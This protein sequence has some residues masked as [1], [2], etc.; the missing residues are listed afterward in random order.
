MRG[1]NILVPI[2][3]HSL[4]DALLLSMQEAD[5]VTGIL[6]EEATL[7]DI[8]PAVICAVLAVYGFFLIRKSKRGEIC[9]MWAETWSQT[10]ENLPE[11]PAETAN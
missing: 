7:S 3:L 6:T 9:R 5:E 1:G 11:I 4:H 2:L 10:T 8:Y